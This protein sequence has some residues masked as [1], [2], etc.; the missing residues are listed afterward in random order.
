MSLA[1]L[2]MYDRPETAAAN[3][4][5]WQAIRAHLGDGPDTL[6]RTGDLWDH[7]L[8]PDLVVSQTCGYP[9]RARLH[10]KVALVGTPDYGLDGCPPGHYR[11]IF[12]AR[13]DDRRTD[14]SDF[15]DAP[16]AYNE[17]LSQSGWAAPQNHARSQG[18]AFTNTHQTGGHALS[19]RAVAEGQADLAALDAL[20][21]KLI[22]RH[23]PFAA[24]L[25][26]IARTP[27]T[28]VLPYITAATND[29]D[30][31]FDA[32]AAAIADLSAEDRATLSLKGLVRLPPEAYLAIPNP[33][34]PA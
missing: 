27:P 11:S 21:W 17:P 32:I 5:Y 25:R 2:P 10:G 29:P 8:A 13:A 34:P 12:V 16:F 19:A 15:A 23:D 14:L 22:Q 24:K 20:T 7:W 9:Y 28:P 1:S 3:D 4:R 33:L 31:I 18:F 26:E 30:A 6:T